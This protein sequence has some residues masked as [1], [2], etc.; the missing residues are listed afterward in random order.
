MGRGPG[1]LTEGDISMRQAI[2]GLVVA[3]SFLV[4]G[5]LVAG[6]Q[7]EREFLAPPDAA[8]VWC[9]STP[10]TEFRALFLSVPLRC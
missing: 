8:K 6:D 1:K 9:Y 7:L 10:I 5:P 4:A 2:V 3:I